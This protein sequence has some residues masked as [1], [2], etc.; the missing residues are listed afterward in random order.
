MKRLL[1]TILF[2]SLFCL[3]SCNSKYDNNNEAVEIEFLT[4]EG[5]FKIFLFNET[6][7]HKENFIELAETNFYDS[8]LFHRVIKNFVIQAGDPSTKTPEAKKLYGEESYGENI[9]AEISPKFN[10]IRGA[11]GAAREGDD[12]NPDKLSS[13]S[14]FYVVLGGNDVSDEDVFMAETRLKNK[15]D[16]TVAKKYKEQGGTPHLDGN[17]TVFGYISE[18]MDVVDKISAFK[19]DRNN[20]PTEDI[21]ILGT[22]INILTETE[23]NEKYINY[24]K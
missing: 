5:S 13:G 12:I 10:H 23:K 17:Y 1:Y 21:K 9:P 6:P 7:K 3:T 4:S 15:I 16:E 18:G 14:H 19:T 22:K 24:A 8:V 2:T 11:V 20:R